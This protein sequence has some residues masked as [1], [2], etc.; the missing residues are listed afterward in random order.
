M[1]ALN[2]P[3]DLIVAQEMSVHFAYAN[4]L[5]NANSKDFPQFEIKNYEVD[6][7]KAFGIQDD[8]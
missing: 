4:S 5:R 6:L 7:N 3:I 1:D 8:N 2:L